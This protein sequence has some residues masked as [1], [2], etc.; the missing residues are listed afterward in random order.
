[1]RR[2][3]TRLFVAGIAAAGLFF[4][5][6]ATTAG[7]ATVGHK[8]PP[9]LILGHFRAVDGHRTA[10]GIFVTR[11]KDMRTGLCLDSNWNGNVYTLGCNNGNFQNWVNV[12]GT[13][14]W[15]DAQTGLC[16]DSNWNGN[17]YTLGCNGGNFQNWYNGLSPVMVDG[18]TSLCLDSNWNGNVYTLGCN[19]GDFQY[20]IQF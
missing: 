12:D 17:V 9:G 13:A 6:G 16:L 18:Q 14:A 8:T 20:W 7:A 3:I 15:S 19:L 1:M 5:A 4:S 10:R 11:L 2:S